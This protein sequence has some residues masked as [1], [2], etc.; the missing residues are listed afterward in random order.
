VVSTDDAVLDDDSFCI[1]RNKERRWAV[2]PPEG[3]SLCS[4]L[5]S[6]APQISPKGLEDQL[7]FCDVP[8]VFPAEAQW[9]PV[10]YLGHTLPSGFQVVVLGTE[11]APGE[12]GYRDQYD[13]TRPIFEALRLPN[14]G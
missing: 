11:S 12:P 3:K 6:S 10:K 5:G 9:V 8:G 7:L 14:T 13:R 1:N 2:P 4:E